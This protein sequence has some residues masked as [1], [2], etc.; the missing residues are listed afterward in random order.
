MSVRV[1]GDPPQHPAEKRLTSEDASTACEMGP[2]GTVWARA[3]GVLG[4]DAVV[5]GSGLGEGAAA[6]FP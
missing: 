4:V 6:G 5:V 3:R 2:D 1:V